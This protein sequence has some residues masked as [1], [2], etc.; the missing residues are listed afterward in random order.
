MACGWP[1]HARGS[2]AIELKQLYTD[3]ARTGGGIGASLMDWALGEA[4]AFRADE[5]QLSVWS[6]NH[7]AQRFYARYGFTK[8][9]DIEFWVGD[10]CDAE[11]LFAL[12]L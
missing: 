9:A 3:P 5:V 2:N 11:F 8:I 7:G 6:E 10:Q 12:M 1:G 4:R